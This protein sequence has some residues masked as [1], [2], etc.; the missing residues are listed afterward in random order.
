MWWG[1]KGGF[2]LREEWQ[3][4]AKEAEIRAA[5]RAGQA[6]Q[7]GQVGCRVDS[8]GATAGKT[9]SREKQGKV[10]IQNKSKVR[11]TWGRRPT[12]ASSHLI[13]RRATMEGYFTPSIFCF[14]K[15]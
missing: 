10:M 6:G 5:F 3:V 13:L 14:R 9:V 7:A 11:V 2:G 8:G 15:H 12:G 1:Q 4:R